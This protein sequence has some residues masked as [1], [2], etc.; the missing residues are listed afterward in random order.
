MKM[1]FLDSFT[2]SLKIIRMSA[3]KKRQVDSECCVFNTEWT[4]KYFVTHVG[5]KAVCLICQNAITV[6]KEYNIK[7]H[8]ST[9]HAN[10]ATN[11]SSQEREQRALKLSSDL[12]YIKDTAQLLIFI[13]GINDEF[14]IVEEFLAMES[15]RG[16]TRGCD[17]YKCVSGCLE[18]F[19]LPWTKL[20]NVTTHESPNLTGKNIRLLRRI[21]DRM[22]DDNPNSDLIF[23]HYIIHQE[24]LCKSVLQL[25]H[26]TKTVVKLV[27]LIRVRG[28]NQ[29][30]F[31]QLLEESG[32]EHRDMLYHSNVRWLSLGKVL[33]R[34]WELRGEIMTFLGNV[35][36]ADEFTE[37]Q[38]L[39]WMCDFAFGVDVLSHLNDL[40]MKLQACICA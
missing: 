18:K 15:M 20:L 34:V 16:T 31:I 37:L 28:L 30:Q 33:H 36:K 6:F 23:L 26:V 10:Y 22:K 27:N 29:H 7:R 13:K 12:T 19:N 14:E 38:D 4:S 2:D 8:F 5:S 25:D 1:R 35:G 11:L 21:Q 17:L 39:D 24:S 9:K 3:E 40:N 32:V